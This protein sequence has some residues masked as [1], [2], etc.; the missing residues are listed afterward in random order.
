MPWIHT[1]ASHALSLL[2]AAEE[3]HGFPDVCAAALGRAFSP[4]VFAPAFQV[5]FCACMFKQENA[6][7]IKVIIKK[8]SL[9]SKQLDL[10]RDV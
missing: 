9:W 8:W 1:A 2:S 3:L 10:P 4:T 5:C 6:V 7:I